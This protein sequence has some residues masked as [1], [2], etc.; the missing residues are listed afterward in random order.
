MEDLYELGN[1]EVENENEKIEYVE[2]IKVVTRGVD[3]SVRELKTLS[4]EKELVVPDFQ[5]EL[6]WDP[7][8]K[9]RFI[10][11]ILLGYPIP[12]MFFT[13]LERGKMLII[14]GQQRINT[15]VEFLNNEL[16]ILRRDD[17]NPKWRGKFFRDLDEDSQRRLR[18]TNIRASVFQILSD[19]QD[20]NI[21]LYSLFERINTGS[22]QLNSQEIRRAIYFGEFTKQLNEFVTSPIWIAAYKMVLPHQTEEFDKDKRLN[23]QEIVARYFTIKSLIDKEHLHNDISYKKEINL[24]MSTA[25]KMDKEFAERI[26]NELDTKLNWLQEQ[27]DISVGHLFRRPTETISNIEDL[28][29]SVK[30]KKFNIPLFESLLLTLDKINMDSGKLDVIKYINLFKDEKFVEAISSQTNRFEN[31]QYR[32]KAMEGVFSRE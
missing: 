4:E 29:V 3:F 10:E 22:I 5:R 32:L 25:Q 1:P 6:V 9:S 20:K 14:D 7:R 12:G 11:S 24:F 13:D 27:I 21:A 18:S 17:I 30:G 26:F 28:S 2:E 23:D 31:I 8:R 15:L 19:D 16:R